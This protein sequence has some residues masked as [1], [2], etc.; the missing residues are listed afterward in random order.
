MFVFNHI[1]GK[2]YSINIT[3]GANVIKILLIK[4]KYCNP[5]YVRKQ[6][7]MKKKTYRVTREPNNRRNFKIVS[8]KILLTCTLDVKQKSLVTLLPICE[9]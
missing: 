9:I 4:E 2:C 7:F 8:S 5:C 6:V 1:A 3:V